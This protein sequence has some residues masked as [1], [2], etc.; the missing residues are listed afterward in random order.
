MTARHPRR[1]AY[2][3][4]AGAVGGVLL[5]IVGVTVFAK[6][7]AGEIID[8]VLAWL[9]DLRLPDIGFPDLP[10]PSIPLP[11]LPDIT[12]PAWVGSI[13]DVAKYVVPVLIALAVTQ[14][15]IKRRAARDGRGDADNPKD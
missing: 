13:A 11:D 15:E 2:R 3:H 9:P 12:M 5:T 7:V 6:T 10:I 1:Y 4:V 8:A 14:A